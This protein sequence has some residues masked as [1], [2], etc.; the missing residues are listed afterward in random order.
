M[1]TNFWVSKD[2]AKSYNGTERVTGPPGA[3]LI[4]RAGLLK[5]KDEPLVI[6]DNAC[7]TG[8]ITALLHDMLS[9]EVTKDMHVT[10]GDISPAMIA[11]TSER[12]A[13]KGWKDVE[14]KIVDAQNTG[15]PDN[16]FTHVLTNI[17][18]MVMPDP[19]AA[20]KECFRMLKPGGVCG[21]TNWKSVGWISDV[22]GAIATIPGAPPFPDM[23]TFFNR[24]APG[25]WYIPD[26]AAQMLTSQGFQD[27]TV[28]TMSFSFITTNG[29][30]FATEFGSMLGHF[31]TK[32]WSAADVEKYVPQVK[33]ALLK[34][35]DEKYGEGKP[36]TTETIA[37]VVTARKPED[38]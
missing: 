36:L 28:E 11:A 35:C 9:P 12:I 1:S 30:A 24:M 27:V 23:I 4:E 21:I 25:E 6:L 37:I 2:I 5:I 10:C 20:L 22:Q 15:L 33:G 3:R 18:I 38:V 34:Y 19:S 7:G 17:G 26:A 31:L 29:Q 32:C 14:A 8:L 13:E 16:T